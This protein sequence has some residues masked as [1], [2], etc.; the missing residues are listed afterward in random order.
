MGVIFTVS[1]CFTCSWFPATTK[2]SCNKGYFRSKLRTGKSTILKEN[3]T[4]KPQHCTTAIPNWT[5]PTHT[6]SFQK[7][8]P[9]QVYQQ[10]LL[11]KPHKVDHWAE[12]Y[13]LR[14]RMEQNRCD[15]GAVPTMAA[16]A[17]WW[18]LAH[19]WKS[20]I[21]LH[22]HSHIFHSQDKETVSVPTVWTWSLRGSEPAFSQDMAQ[23]CQE[24]DSLLLPISFSLC[25]SGLRVLHPPFLQDPGTC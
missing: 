12:S 21:F 10:R 24:E 3:Q 22:S 15:D 16:Y 13:Q 4:I 7:C 9:L 19:L 1:L 5:I 25:C 6:E 11:V 8:N 20:E 18:E 17:H 14:S 2:R 23:R